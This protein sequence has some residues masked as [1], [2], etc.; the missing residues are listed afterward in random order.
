MAKKVEKTHNPK[1]VATRLKSM[2]QGFKTVFQPT[3][4]VD[5]EGTLT[6]AGQAA[7]ELD[8]DL[9]R[10]TNTD[11]AHEAYEGAKEDRDT[12]QPAVLARLDAFEIGLRAKLGTTSQKLVDFGLK[13]K[14]KGKR[15]AASK[16]KAAA[17]AKA[18]RQQHDGKQAPPAAP[19]A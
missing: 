17:K 9:G 12:N 7:G 18:T 15:S 13:P 5:V 19:E 14:A 16:A 4:T 2:S 10:Y 8:A 1:A 3:D 11:T 6:P